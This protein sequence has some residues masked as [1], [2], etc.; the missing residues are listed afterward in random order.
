VVPAPFRNF[1][2]FHSPK[3]EIRNGDLSNVQILH[4]DRLKHKEQLSSLS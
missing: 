2:D 3:F 1:N 4:R